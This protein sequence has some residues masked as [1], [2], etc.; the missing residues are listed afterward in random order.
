MRW[1]W[2]LG[3]LLLLPSWAGAQ[4]SVDD[5]L[6]AMERGDYAAAVRI[7]TPLAENS[8]HAEPIAQFL[9]GLLYSSGLGVQSSSAISVRACGLFLASA[10]A[11]NP[12]SNQALALARLIHRDAPPL[13]RLCA[14]AGLYPWSEPPPVTFELEPGW[15]VRVERGRPI[16][17]QHGAE[18][19]AMASFEGPGGV[20]SSIEHTTLEV[21]QTSARRH[22]LEV[23]FWTP[24]LDADSGWAL[25]W[26]VGEIVG[27]D[28]K[29]V[30]ISGQQ[31]TLALA[32]QPQA[33]IDARK[34]VRLAVNVDGEVE[35]TITGLQPGR[36][37]IP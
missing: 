36:G 13:K 6:Q 14:A 5:G 7:L 2:F 27:L 18:R 33:S 31:A 28:I 21:P 9:L 1:T 19:I 4:T 37:I 26:Y 3:V 23:F 34:L 16:V 30:P 8:A 25:M 10:V 12:L 35:W 11:S 17:R 29:G 15:T 20:F 22:F 24:R 32:D